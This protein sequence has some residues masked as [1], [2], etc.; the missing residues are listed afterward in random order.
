MHNLAAAKPN[1][2]VS[3]IPRNTVK[4]TDWRWRPSCG[5]NNCANAFKREFTAS[6]TNLE[7]FCSSWTAEP[8]A[9]FAPT[10]TASWAANCVGPSTA[11]SLQTAV[12]SKVSSACSCFVPEPTTCPGSGDEGYRFLTPE[13]ERRSSLSL[14]FSISNRKKHTR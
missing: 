5:G 7:S 14:V 12:A 1:S 9:V 8:S 13:T 10:G 4:F 2:S 11:S 3:S 6:L